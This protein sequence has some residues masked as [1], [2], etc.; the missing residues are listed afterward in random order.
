MVKTALTGEALE[1][2]LL[3]GDLTKAQY[4]LTG[5]VKASQNK[6]HISFSQAGCEAWIDIPTDLIEKAEHLGQTPC[7]DHFHPLMSLE[8][9]E[10]SD[11]MAKTLLSLLAKQ[12]TIRPTTPMQ[13]MIGSHYRQ[14][15]AFDPTIPQSSLIPQQSAVPYG[16][17]FGSAGAWFGGGVIFD[18]SFPCCCS[19]ATM[20]CEGGYCWP[21]TYRVC[22]SC[23]GGRCECS[24]TGP[25][26]GPGPIIVA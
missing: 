8:L 16:R 17:T 24:S 3:E 18:P 6:G 11:P 25:S 23:P 9:K 4:R 21:V 12:E 10:S 2:A 20:R 1:K 14:S 22:I 7:S 19:Y 5:M 13:N 15:D 26:C